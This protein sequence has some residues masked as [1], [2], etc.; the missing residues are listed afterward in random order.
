MI[1]YLEKATTEIGKSRKD[2]I[3]RLV[4]FSQTDMLLFWGP[5]KGLIERQEKIWGPILKWVNEEVN[6]KFV[7]TQS[8]DVP[9]NKAS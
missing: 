4:V 3:D 8:L 7:K 5:E 9:E 1:S 6:V 2:V